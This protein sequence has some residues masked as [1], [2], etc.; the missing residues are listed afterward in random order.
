MKEKMI[1]ILKE[2]QQMKD[3]FRSRTMQHIGRV[4]ENARQL[5][6]EFPDIG[7]ELLK[8]V[9]GHDD[10]KFEDPE[11]KPYLHI[12]WKYKVADEG[13]E[14]NPPQ[15]ILDSMHEATMH[16]ILNNKHHPEFHDE[17]FDSRSLSKADRDSVPEK[18]VD[19]QLMDKVSIA[20]MVCDWVAM[21]QEK[22]G[23]NDASDW[24]EMN[25]NK[26][27]KFTEQQVI[28]I[29]MYHGFFQK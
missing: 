2:A 22:S 6:N 28:W 29:H 8:Q 21:S 20:E 25:V 9:S 15:E 12:S 10:S 14:Y 26:R 5:A 13:G 16:H 11:Y 1:D 24:I 7:T 23:N 19:A 18:M 3:H 27:W 4:K 17:G